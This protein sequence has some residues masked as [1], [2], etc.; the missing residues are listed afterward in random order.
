[1][2]EIKFRMWDIRTGK[3]LA[4]PDLDRIDLFELIQDANWAAADGSPT[5]RVFMQYTGLKDANGTEIYEGDVLGWAVDE[6][7]SLFYVQWGEITNEEDI[8]GYGWV[9]RYWSEIN[10]YNAPQWFTM[11]VDGA[12]MKVIGNIYEHPH[13]I[14]TEAV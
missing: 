13:L 3:M 6:D 2:R 7:G 12:D 11:P 14:E 8:T 4:W 5:H 9:V 1:M 10:I